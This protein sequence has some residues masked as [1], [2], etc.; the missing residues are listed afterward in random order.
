MV[1]AIVEVHRR[2]EEIGGFRFSY[3]A[4]ALR[5]FTATFEPLYQVG[6]GRGA[7]L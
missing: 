4:P 3:Q 1:E 6:K 5:H 7:G 2:R